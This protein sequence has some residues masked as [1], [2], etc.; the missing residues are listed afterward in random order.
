MKRFFYRLWQWIWGLPQTLTGALLCLFLGKR[1]RFWYQGALVTIW[2]LPSSM[3][4]GMF[5]FLRPD[6]RP[7]Q[8]DLLAHEYGHTVQSLLLGPLYLPLIGLPSLLWAG[9]PVMDRIRAR[10]RL[11][12]SWLYCERWADRCGA[13]WAKADIAE[14][15]KKTA[16]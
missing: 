4:L 6:W 2:S 7:E 9:L 1:R 15:A 3:S 13:R 14:K 11:P 16:K 5:L 12:Y 8:R 10:R